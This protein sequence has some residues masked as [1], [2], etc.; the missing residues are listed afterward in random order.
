LFA[1]G[2]ELFGGTRLIDQIDCFVGKLTIRDVAGSE[3]RGGDESIILNFRAM[4]LLVPR[5]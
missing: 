2:L 5:L 3:V 1:A 4:V